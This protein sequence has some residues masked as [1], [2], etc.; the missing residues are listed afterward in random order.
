[1]RPATTW[2]LFPVVVLQVLFLL[3]LDKQG[4]HGFG[5]IIGRQHN[6]HYRHHT[7]YCVHQ[8][9][10]WRCRRRSHCRSLAA[11]GY[12]ETDDASKGV[13]QTLTNWVNMVSDVFGGVT[14]TTTTTTSS[15]DD[16]DGGVSHQVT[17]TNDESLRQLSVLPISPEDV[18]ERI[19]ADYMERNYLWTGNID[20][21]AFDVNCT[22]QDPTLQFQG[23]DTFVRNVQNIRRLS[24]PLLG[25]C[26]SELQH[27]ALVDSNMGNNDNQ[28]D[29]NIYY[30]QTQWRMVGLLKGLPWQPCIDVPGRTKFWLSSSH[31]KMLTTNYS[32]WQVTKY[33][34]E[35]DI[36]AAK[37]L[38]QLVIPSGRYPEATS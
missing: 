10:S 30:V 27:I 12:D 21:A 1:M 15:D 36:P 11:K 35:W 16:E 18:L 8:K 34:E 6:H 5:I 24:D 13:V 22:F 9:N 37:A 29:S 32:Y 3:D 25:P 28:L 17:T 38:L 31:Y 20:L 23:R 14:S 19:R 2:P 7:S 4:S 33:E 26:R